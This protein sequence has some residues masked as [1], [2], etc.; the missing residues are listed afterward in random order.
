MTNF[1]VFF[2]SE[3]AVASRTIYS[4]LFHSV[5]FPVTK[6]WWHHQTI[7]VL[8]PFTIFGCIPTIITL[9]EKCARKMEFDFVD[10][11]T[12]TL[13]T[14]LDQFNGSLWNMG[15]NVLKKS[16]LSLL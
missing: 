12:L 2:P 8:G 13:T 9:A 15:K 10:Q 14:T 11:I 3:Y 16:F 7:V 4:T 5:N 6:R 1:H